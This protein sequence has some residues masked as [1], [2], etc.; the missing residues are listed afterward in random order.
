[1]PPI[2]ADQLLL[3]NYY[4]GLLVGVAAALAVVGSCGDPRWFARVYYQP[5]AGRTPEEGVC[6]ST[7]PWVGGVA[8]FGVGGGLSVAQSAQG[9]IPVAAL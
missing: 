5:P 2:G 4:C 8:G 6:R 3:T 7:V 9:A 1:M